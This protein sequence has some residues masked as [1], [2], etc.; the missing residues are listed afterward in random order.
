M[1]WRLLVGIALGFGIGF[2]CRALGIPVPAPPLLQG[3]LLVLAMTTGYLLA[4][5]FLARRVAL[6]A[7]NCGGPDGR[8]ARG[9]S[10]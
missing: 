5:R 8:S 4:D 7:D 1:N 10:R 9:A 3:A 2:G 6:N